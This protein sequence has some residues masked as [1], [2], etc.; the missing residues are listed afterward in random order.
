MRRTRQA[1]ALRDACRL[2]E[3]AQVT[4]KYRA[5]RYL[6]GAKQSHRTYNRK[7]LVQSDSLHD[8]DGESRII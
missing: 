3:W 4:T 5:L 7:C 2:Y 1:A 6:G 8:R